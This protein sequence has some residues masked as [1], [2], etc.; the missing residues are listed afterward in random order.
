VRRTHNF[1]GNIIEDRQT[2]RG[3]QRQKQI[4]GGSTRLASAAPEQPT[5]HLL[6][7]PLLI[8]KRFFPQRSL[9]FAGKRGTSFVRLFITTSLFVLAA[10]LTL[11][12]STA[13]ASTATASVENLHETLTEAMKQADALGYQGR[14]DLIAPAV[15]AHIDQKFMASKSIGRAWKKLSE[16][17]QELWL[18]SFSNLTVANYA[19]RFKGYSGEHFVTNAE[20]D[21][22]HKT[23]LVSTTLVL[24]NDDDVK[25]NY[26]LHET[27][28]GW[29]II[30]VYMNGTVSELSLR[31]SEYS[32][33]LKRKGF[34][35]LLTA[36]SEKLSKFAAGNVANDRTQITTGKSDAP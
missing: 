7:F 5:R 16:A 6:W 23:K 34:D 3:S 18:Q 2:P 12:S 36:V 15:N 8:G 24:P 26:R 22:P 19:G 14:F 33:T 20:Q 32:S 1:R 27:E 11:S 13:T 10:C 28:A 25:L 31:R 17:E 4:D 35:S 30:D 9:R 21:A 29:K